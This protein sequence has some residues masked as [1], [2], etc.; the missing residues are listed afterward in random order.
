M[1]INNAALF[2]LIRG[3]LFIALIALSKTTSHNGN[4]ENSPFPDSKENLNPA[5]NPH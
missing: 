4:V 2:A 3:F 5:N 1:P